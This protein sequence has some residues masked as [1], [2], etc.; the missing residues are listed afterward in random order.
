ML[1]VIVFFLCTSFSC[2]KKETVSPASANQTT[3]AQQQTPSTRDLLCRKWKLIKITEFQIYLP[4]RIEIPTENEQTILFFKSDG[5]F[6]EEYSTNP[7]QNEGTWS[8][9]DEKKLSIK[10]TKVEKNVKQ[11]LNDNSFQQGWCISIS[12][13]DTLKMAQCMNDDMVVTYV[14]APIEQKQ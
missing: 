6:T 3:T 1:L 7:S 9:M 13:I 5:F 14:Y 2:N 11:S 8:L 4:T 10:Y 12:S